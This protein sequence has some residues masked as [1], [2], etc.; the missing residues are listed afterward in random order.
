MNND[1]REHK[2]A[3]EQKVWGEKRKSTREQMGKNSRLKTK[4]CKRIS[5]L[6]RNS[7]SLI[8][9]KN[10]QPLKGLWTLLS[11]KH[12]NLIIKTQRYA[13]WCCNKTKEHLYCISIHICSK[14]VTSAC[15]FS[16]QTQNSREMEYK[17]ASN[18][19]MFHK[20]SNVLLQLCSMLY[21]SE[22]IYN[23]FILETLMEITF[24]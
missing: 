10:D 6:R 9:N 3:Y 22:T 4:N 5:V 24:S 15:P 1:I 12:Y 21:C 7:D 11:I 2:E 23:Q 13:A 18:Q 20:N 14:F 16:I 19:T 17:S 8:I